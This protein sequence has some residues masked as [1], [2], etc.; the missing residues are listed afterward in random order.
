M[1][2]LIVTKSAFLGCVSSRE[3]GED[4][5][6]QGVGVGGGGGG[7]SFQAVDFLRE[8]GLGGHLTVNELVLLA[9][10]MKKISVRLETH[11]SPIAQ[12]LH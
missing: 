1:E 11:Y 7:S 8:R 4:D 12:P 3:I 2:L 6:Q 10:S 5:D 9:A